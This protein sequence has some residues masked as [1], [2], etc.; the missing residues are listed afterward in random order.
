VI[1]RALET[2][3]RTLGLSWTVDGFGKIVNSFMELE[4]YPEANETLMELNK[5]NKPFTIVSDGSHNMLFHLI[6]KTKLS[7][8]NEE[9]KEGMVI[10]AEEL[11]VFKPNKAVYQAAQ[12]KMSKIS[13][14]KL[15]YVTS[16]YWDAAGARAAGFKNVVYLQRP[17][18]HKCFD[19]YEKELAPCCTIFSL[20]DL[21]SSTPVVGEKKQAPE[22]TKKSEQ[23]QEGISCPQKP[24]LKNG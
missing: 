16:S 11:G 6:N 21:I 18:A 12:K 14:E 17:S 13:P 1:S 9:V 24:I 20:C 10:S 23:K 5:L 19:I 7:Q 2:S 8:L 15:A 22:E 4:A 3:L